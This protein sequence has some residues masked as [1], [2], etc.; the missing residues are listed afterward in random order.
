MFLLFFW[1][2]KSVSDLEGLILLTVLCSSMNVLI[3]SAVLVGFSI[4]YRLQK[5]EHM[6]VYQ[7]QYH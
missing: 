6:I 4:R 2:T 7:Q 3:I 5:G 1:K